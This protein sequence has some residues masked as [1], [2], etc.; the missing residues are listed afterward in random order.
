MIYPHKG[1]DEDEI[2][3]DIIP[4]IYGSKGLARV[5]QFKPKTKRNFTYKDKTLKDFGE[6]FSPSEIGKYSG[7]IAYICDKIRNSEGIVFVYSQYIDGGAVPIALALES[8]GITRYGTTSS[9]FKKAPTNP[10]NVLT[11]KPKKD[12]EEFKPAKYIMITGQKTL[13]PDVKKE[14]KAVTDAGNANG[15]KVKVI[16]VSSAGSEGLDFQNIR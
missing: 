14:I 5:M 10:L 16:I 7:K 9:L 2:D 6:I 13:T 1:L 4:F 8:M 3:S 15:E 11:M 12:N